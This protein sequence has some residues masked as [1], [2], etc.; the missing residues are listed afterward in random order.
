M[1]RYYNYSQTLCIK[2]PNF[3]ISY[4][5]LMQFQ[6]FGDTTDLRLKGGVWGWKEEQDR[7]KTG[8]LYG[9]LYGITFFQLFRLFLKIYVLGKPVMHVW[10]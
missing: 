7:V 8:C 4:P 6:Y 2:L 10:E 1:Y 5:D 9:Y 3:K